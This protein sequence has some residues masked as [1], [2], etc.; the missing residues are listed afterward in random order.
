MAVRALKRLTQEVQSLP[1][2]TVR[3]CLK[4]NKTKQNKNA[5]KSRYEG[6]IKTFTNK[7]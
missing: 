7:N 1:R 5:T 3:P 2:K 6:H 4:Q